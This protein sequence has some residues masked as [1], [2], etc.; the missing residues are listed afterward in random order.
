MHTC[1][2][3][4]LLIIHTLKISFL[5]LKQQ[6]GGNVPWSYCERTNSLDDRASLVYSDRCHCPSTSVVRDAQRWRHNRFLDHVLPWFTR[7]SSA[8]S[9]RLPSTLPCSM[10][11]CSVSWRQTW[12]NHD[13]LRDCVL[14]PNGARKVCVL[15]RSR[16]GMLGWIT[17]RKWREIE[18]KFL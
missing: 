13:N 4:S 12:P 11:F 10:I 18:K 8:T 16:T 17:R 3:W 15:R 1:I 6:K 5:V 2:V 14:W 7:S 9:W